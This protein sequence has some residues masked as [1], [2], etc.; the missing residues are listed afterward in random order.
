MPQ[1]A[2]EILRKRIDE[3]KQRLID[4]TRKNGLI[5]YKRTKSSTLEITLPSADQI[6]RTI[7]IEN[8]SFAFWLPPEEPEEPLS[9][10]TDASDTDRQTSTTSEDG[11][12]MCSSSDNEQALAA[13]EKIVEGIVASAPGA[14]FPTELYNVLVAEKLDRKTINNTL[15][16]L[17]RKE[18]EE[19]RERGIRVLFLAFGMLVWKEENATESLRSPLLLFPVELKRESAHHPF[20]LFPADEDLVINPALAV[21]L[22]REFNIELPPLT[23][24]LDE[25]NVEEYLASVKD[26]IQE[27]GWA[28]EPTV[29]LRI[30][31]FEKLGMYQDLEKNFEIIA[32]HMCVN[33]LCGGGLPQSDLADIRDIRNLDNVQKPETTYQILDADS[34]QQQAIQV[35]LRGQSMV[36]QGPPGTGKSQTI[37]NIIAEFIARGKTVLFASEKMAAL[38]V[39]AKRLREAKLGTFCLELHSRKKNKKEVVDELYSCMENRLEPQNSLKVEDYARLSAHRKRLNEYVTALHEYRSEIGRTARQAFVAATDDIE[40][41]ELGMTRLDELS[42]SRVQIWEDT[43]RSMVPLWHVAVEGKNFPWRGCLESDYS[44]AVERKWVALLNETAEAADALQRLKEHTIEITGLQVADSLSETKW[45][46]EMLTHLEGRKTPDPAWLT[47][48]ALDEILSEAKEYDCLSRS[49]WTN[50]LELASRY[51]ES[52]FSLTPETSQ[53]ISTAWANAATKLLVEPDGSK[54]LAGHDKLAKMLDYLPSLLERLEDDCNLLSSAFDCETAPFSLKS[55]EGLRYLASLCLSKNHPEERWLTTEGIE[56]AKTFVNTNQ[57]YYTDFVRIKADLLTR[58]EEEYLKLDHTELALRF[59]GITYKAP[60]AWLNPGWYTARKQ[61]LSLT[62]DFRL[63]DDIL[64][65]FNIGRSL[66]RLSRKLEAL[67]PAAQEALGAYF[68]GEDTDFAEISLALDTADALLKATGGEVPSGLVACAKQGGRFSAQAV[69]AAKRVAENGETIWSVSRHLAGYIDVSKMAL[70]GRPFEECNTKELIHWTQELSDALRRLAAGLDCIHTAEGH[71][72]SESLEQIHSDLVSKFNLDSIAEGMKKESERLQSLFGK[73]FCGLDTGWSEVMAAIEWTQ[74]FKRLN[75]GREISEKLAQ[76]LSSGDAPPYNSATIR[77]ANARIERAMKIIED[78]FEHNLIQFQSCGFLNISGKTRLLIERVKDLEYWVDYK[79]AF[80]RLCSVGLKNFIQNISE[81][82]PHS[83]ELIRL[84]KK[85]IAA[86]QVR[87]LI[88]TV[89]AL[90]NFKGVNHEQLVAEFRIIDRKIV[91][92]TPASIIHA[93]NARRPTANGFDAQGSEVTLLR[94]EANKSR[95]ILPL[96][97]LFERIP[98]L[99]LKL[100]PCLMMSPLSVSQY[101]NP[102]RFSF[103]LVIFDEASQIFTEDAVVAIYRGKQVVVA[104]DSKQMPP[105]SFFSSLGEEPETDDNEETFSSVGYS[106]VL[107]ECEAFLPPFPLRWHYRSRHESLITYSNSAFYRN[108]VTFPSA[109]AEHPDYGVQ[110]VHVPDGVY[111]RGGRRWNLR[112]AEVVAEQVFK[113][114]EVHPGKSLGVV[115]FSRQQ[116]DAIEDALEKMRNEDSAYEGFFNEDRLEGF[117]V[118][119]LE[120]VQGDERDVMIFSIGYGYDRQGRMTMSFGPLN[121]EG[122]ERRLNVAITR[123]REKVLVVSSIK[124]SDFDL[125]QNPKPGALH[126]YRYLDYAERGP[127]ALE[128]THPAGRGEEESPFEESVAAVIRE[129]GYTVIPQVGCSGYRIDLGI[130]HP[131]EPGRFFL[132]VE[133]DGASYH[134]GET[135]R[136]RDRLRQQVLERLGWRIYR[137]W[138]Q[139]WFRHK[140]RQIENL[141]KSLEEAVKAPTSIPRTDPVE[142]AAARVSV[143]KVQIPEAKPINVQDLKGTVEYQICNL[144]GQQGDLPFHVAENLNRLAWLARK[145]VDTEGPVHINIVA[146]RLAEAYSLTKVG[147]RMRQAVYTAVNRAANGGNIIIQGEFLWPK[148]QSEVIPRIPGRSEASHRAVEL[149]AP[150]EIQTAMEL[151]IRQCVG[152]SLDGLI[153]ETARM[154]GIQRATPRIRGI[155]ETVAKEMQQKGAATLNGDSLTLKK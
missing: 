43:L 62:H 75:E 121:Q 128:I 9:S 83:G 116:A 49:Y 127:S 95:R 52:F 118:K 21:K 7:C 132:G 143:K 2:D 19:Y 59:S 34:S 74:S 65:D 12:V 125:S 44:A 16:N 119:S 37:A 145:I 20:E 134:S 41:V 107:D 135:A 78:S 11:N 76:F 144:S 72:G 69:E 104:G 77:A 61:L 98:N 120:N 137:I 39:V 102:D 103:D 57:E 149:I 141:K 35:V 10:E 142:P 86:E 123:A 81:S 73:R 113:H 151:I 14:E 46:V 6:F 24:E 155:L 136:D 122:G 47:S 50:R 40:A 17:Y 8:N 154:F 58:Y 147:E 60:F 31:T 114:F 13:G 99:L 54:L 126:L 150:E 1:I 38:E 129:L 133:C 27:R 139:D 96:V 28:V 18:T 90:A 23:E 146:K 67:R 148:N 63:P 15:K 32:G 105:T 80:G 94:R 115:A 112:E 92:L 152:I 131:A 89:P 97:T 45:L 68:K 111:E 82:P 71:S 5:N 88:E 55:A 33:A 64:A 87:I 66:S 109:V 26:L 153:T 138:S 25:M 110:M 106:S 100:K 56:R 79:S 117:F 51:D 130:L 124:A 36:L 101:I 48:S 22:R 84:L 85:S 70:L 140:E 30:F 93:C 29:A 42:P 4:L 53:R 3:W 91:E 108:L